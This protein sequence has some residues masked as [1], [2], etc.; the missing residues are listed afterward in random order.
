MGSFGRKLL[1]P[2]LYTLVSHP[3]FYAFEST[4][5]DLHDVPRTSENV[6]TVSKLPSNQAGEMAQDEQVVIRNPLDRKVSGPL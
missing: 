2:A 5:T 3:K 4:P 1:Q 6:R